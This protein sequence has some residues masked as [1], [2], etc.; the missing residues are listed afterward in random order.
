MDWYTGSD[1]GP[2]CWISELW[3]QYKLQ[4]GPWMLPQGAS[5]LYG[6]TIE[7]KQTLNQVIQPNQD[8]RTARRL[9]TVHV[10]DLMQPVCWISEMSVQQRLQLGPWMLPQGASGW[11]GPAI[12]P[13]QTLTQVVQPNWGWQ[14]DHRLC[15]VHA[16]TKSYASSL[17]F[18]LF[19]LSILVIQIKCA[20]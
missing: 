1:L 5:V 6:R 16:R 8:W 3:V 20:Y 7:P 14:T 11:C 9:C 4:L 17:F 13:K 15:T 18:F 2:V 10:Q 12:E 19:G